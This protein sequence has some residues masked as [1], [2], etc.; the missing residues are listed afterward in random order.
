LL[1]SPGEQSRARGVAARG[2]HIPRGETNAIGN[3]SVDVRRRD[4]SA[5][6]RNVAVTQVGGEED[7]DIGSVCP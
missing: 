4:V 3:E 1:V 2:S 6:V 7:E 5:V